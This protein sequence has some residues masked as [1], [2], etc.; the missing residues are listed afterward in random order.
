MYLLTLTTT[1]KGNHLQGHEQVLFNTVLTFPPGL[2]SYKWSACVSLR[3]YKHNDLPIMQNTM[4]TFRSMFYILKNWNE[5][6]NK[7][8]NDCMETE[9]KEPTYGLMTITTRGGWGGEYLVKLVFWPL[10]LCTGEKRAA[11]KPWTLLGRLVF[12][13][14][15][16]I[17]ILELSVHHRAEQEVNVLMLLGTREIQMWMGGWGRTLWNLLSIGAL[18][19]TLFLALPP[20]R[21]ALCV[22]CPIWCHQPHAA[23]EL[24]RWLVQLRNWKFY[25]I[26]L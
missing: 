26:S 6:N 14:G 5:I 2:W 10:S 12:Q 21:N 13:R 15:M 7:D 1:T 18:T 22:H 25:F 23:T 11:N 19:W 9:T 3:V 16:T 4:L 8:E 24:K 20:K 17:A